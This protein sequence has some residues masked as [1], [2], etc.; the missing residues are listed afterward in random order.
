MRVFVLLAALVSGCLGY[1]KRRPLSLAKFLRSPYARSQNAQGHLRDNLPVYSFETYIVNQTTDHFSFGPVTPPTFQQRILINATYW[2][3]PK[4]PILF[5]TGNEGPIES[6]AQNTGFM[7]DIAPHLGA[8]VV[9]AEHRY[10]GESTP[11]PGE[12]L[13]A[14]P[15]NATKLAYLSTEQALRGANIFFNLWEITRII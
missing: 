12:N 13:F 6:F 1:S 2:K 9:F 14:D 5:Y 10:Y 11:F 4:Y 7:W 8:M 3:G 15:V